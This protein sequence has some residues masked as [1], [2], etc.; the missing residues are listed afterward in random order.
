MANRNVCSKNITIDGRKVS[1]ATH[2][3]WALSSEGAPIRIRHYRDLLRTGVFAGERPASNMVRSL[4]TGDEVHVLALAKDGASLSNDEIAALLGWA[5]NGPAGFVGSFESAKEKAGLANSF[6]GVTRDARRATNVKMPAD[7]LLLGEGGWGHRRS[8]ASELLMLARSDRSSDAYYETAKERGARRRHLVAHLTKK[9]P[10]ALVSLVTALRTKDNLRAA[11]LM[12][13]VDAAAAGHPDA[14]ALLAAAMLRPDEPGRALR[15]FFDAY[16]D[17][18][19]QGLPSN[20]RRAVGAAAANLYTEDAVLRFDRRRYV[21][22]ED[23]AD[24]GR[25]VRFADVLSLTH[26]S[27]RDDEQSRLFG[28]LVGAGD[29]PPLLAERERLSSLSAERVV[30]ELE[31][32]ARRLAAGGEP[33]L[34]SRLPWE[35]LASFSATGRT[36]VTFAKEAFAAAKAARSTFRTD[37]ENVRVLRE[38]RRLRTRLRDAYRRTG[39]GSAAVRNTARAELAAFVSA[40]EAARMLAAKT[41][42]DAR[43]EST[44]LELTAASKRAG[45]VHP[46]VWSIALPSLSNSQVL[47]LLGSFDRSGL[48]AA[49]HS[50]VEE[51]LVSASV[52][53]PDILRAVRGSALA[54]AGHGAEASRVEFGGP[55]VW[56]SLPPSSW[57]SSLD[58]LAADRV[59]EKLP[60][61]KGRVLILVDG[62]GSMHA[63]VSGRRNDRRAEGYHSLSCADVAG[64]AASAIA[65]R[66]VDGADVYVYDT[67]VTEVENLADG[68]VAATRDILG[69]IRGGGTDTHG[70]IASTWNDHDLLVVLTDEQT[71]HVPGQGFASP[72]Y[73]R[74]EAT[75]SFRLPAA[76]KVVTV[77]LAGYAGAH[78]DDAPNRRSISGWSESLFDEIRE[79]NDMPVAPEVRGA[80]TTVTCP[81]CEEPVETG[82]RYP[83]TQARAL[84]THK[85]KCPKK[86]FLGGALEIDHGSPSDSYDVEAAE[87]SEARMARLLD[88]PSDPPV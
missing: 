75:R 55:G 33:G 25:P 73:V 3:F 38:E 71:M 12:I 42:I 53:I 13:A 35:T 20:I 72:G 66:C 62:S 79:L 36:D 9:D 46:A 44:R 70:A 11:A 1:F 4:G 14:E 69:N 61:I 27:P 54:A 64:F 58:R 17:G 39:E 63:E 37:P 45:K 49:T 6:L 84:S 48:D 21:G 50:R 19:R 78:L 60:E 86:R 10:T 5:E 80:A 30:S 2:A 7:R 76:A 22:V 43:V 83:E 18:R 87:D 56:T 40:P 28:F 47:S 34:L 24:R 26:P 59:A 77:N 68:V 88:D 15:Y 16:R 82:S 29:P 23:R 57:E 81:Y 74:D 31:T 32:E 51:R 67:E 8:P 85:A 52:A 65:S 41:E